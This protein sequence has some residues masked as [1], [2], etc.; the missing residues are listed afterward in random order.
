MCEYI[1]ITDTDDQR[2]GGG[3]NTLR[4]SLVGEDFVCNTPY[5]I[6]SPQYSDVQYSGT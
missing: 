1:Y 5:V 2:V 4:R 3:A 6:N